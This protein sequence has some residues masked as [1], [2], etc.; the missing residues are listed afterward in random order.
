MS[1]VKQDWRRLAFRLC[2]QLDIPVLVTDL[3]AG[4]L[5][6]RDLLKISM[7]TRELNLEA[8]A[9]IYR[10]IVI[11]LDGGERPVKKASLL[12]RTF[13]ANKTA[14]SAVR[15]LSLAGDFL[16]HWRLSRTERDESAEYLLRGQTPPDIHADLSDFSQKESELC[17]QLRSFT[18]A[19]EMPLW[20]LC[21]HISV[22]RL[23]SST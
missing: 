7:L 13:S 3:I 8:N 15:S 16:T 4:Y 19:Q 11:D 9:S 23:A 1:T 18:A 2:E 12:F 10:D 5:D 14:A 20:E 17:G 6:G 22:S 21:L